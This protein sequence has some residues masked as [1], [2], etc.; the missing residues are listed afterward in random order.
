MGCD[1]MQSAIGIN[2]LEDLAASI[3]R[4]EILHLQTPTEQHAQKINHLIHLLVI[5]F[6]LSFH[7]YSLLFKDTF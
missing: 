1:A 2:I 7:D 6:T 5:C 3:F 4:E